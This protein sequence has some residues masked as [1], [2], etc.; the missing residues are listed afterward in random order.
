[1]KFKSLIISI[2]FGSLILASCVDDLKFGN[3]S[4]E[5]EPGVDTT[6]DTI[7]SKAEY[8]RRF[9]WTSYSRLY[10]GL[11]VYWDND[12][13]KMNMGMFETLSDSWHSHLSWDGV[14]RLYYSGS[15][16]AGVEN[17]S[18]D[19]KFGFY[20]ENVWNTVRACW[21][22][23]ENVDRV[24][25][26]DAAEKERLKAEAK[27]II[28]SRYFDAFRHY[29]GLPIIDHSYTVSS[30]ASANKTPRATVE[31]TTDFMVGLL[32]QA[33][34]VLPWALNES[35]IANWDGRFTKAA[36]M[37]LKCKILLFS[38]SPLFNDTEPFSKESP[39]ESVTNHHVWTGSYKPE[40][41]NKCL[42]A[43]EE[44]FAEVESK[45]I[46]RLLTTSGTTQSA[47]RNAFRD[48]YLSRGSGG[49]NPELLISTRVRYTYS[50]NPWDYYFPQSC[51]NG[52]FSPTQEYVEM[53][54]MAD[55]TPFSWKN[56][57]HVKKMFTERDPRLF[58]TV[59]VDGVS[60]KGRQVELWVG[61]RE[62]QQGPAQESGEFAT[63]YALYK[64]ILDYNSSNNKP[65][66]WPYLRIAEIHLIYAEALMKAGRFTEAIAQVDLVRKRVGLK[67]LVECNPS[68][69]LNSEKDLL[70][71][72]LRERACELGFEDVRFFDL[73]RHKRVSDFT[74]PLHG[75]RIYR[76]D[77]KQESWSD[78]PSD[79]RGPRPT[80]FTYE[81]FEL[82][83][84]KRA[85]WTKFSTK[86]FLSA[87]PPN[88]I[89]K[90]YGLT[91]NPGW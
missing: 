90:D 77:G 23:I 72:I 85:W 31:E 43:C 33:A 84:A 12:K 78:K 2:F 46:Y 27:V 3:N 36:A 17:D 69:N 22:F 30:D 87:F 13:K 32:D 73:I 59:L 80:E 35:D 45:G 76:A 53:F 21:I 51:Q 60:Y 49:A 42:K 81:V 25:D 63:G 83:N 11:P 39:Q 34:Q 1:M 75:L 55:G 54:P 74:K 26:M 71:E 20:R 18:S 29:G 48:A 7:F 79:T 52:A 10:Y 70:E 86:W 6:Q 66:L 4:L 65:T 88:E 67:G 14:N 50:G 44:F 15:Y 9:L 5:K 16:S 56:P 40:L 47:Y 62:A 58:E 89:N 19:S 28:A 91:Q 57:D 82:G 37:G 68:K 38:A 24:P 64:F 41:W 8:A 61:G